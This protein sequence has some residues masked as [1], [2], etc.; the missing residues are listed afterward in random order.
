M[1]GSMLGVRAR[2]VYSGA[3]IRAHATGAVPVAVPG[4]RS[5][6]ALRGMLR[7]LSKAQT[8]EYVQ[9]VGKFLFHCLSAYIS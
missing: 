8:I 3:L 5:R 1:P 2:G 7:G 4:A 9:N 6:H